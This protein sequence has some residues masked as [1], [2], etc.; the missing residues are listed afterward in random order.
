[1]LDDVETANL[2]AKAPNDE[3]MGKIKFYI[4]YKAL[5]D[6]AKAAYLLESTDRFDL[7]QLWFPKD[8]LLKMQC[9]ADITANLSKV[10]FQELI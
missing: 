5:G 2:S 8:P 6:D 10:P 1:M 4:A 9:I 3:Y 7:L